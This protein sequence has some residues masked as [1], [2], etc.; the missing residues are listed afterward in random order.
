MEL[1]CDC[2]WNS[3]GAA[4]LRSDMAAHPDLSNEIPASSSHNVY[5]SSSQGPFPFA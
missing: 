1:H 3:T 5:L 4:N 2:V